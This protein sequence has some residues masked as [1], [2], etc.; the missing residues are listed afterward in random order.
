MLGDGNFVVTRW[1][2]TGTQRGELMGIKP[3][4][5]RAVTHGCSVSQIKDGKPVH[6]WIYWD[7]GYLLR[8]LGVSPAP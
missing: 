8:Q 1:T 3:T 6:D 2:T 5:R 4:N 7:T